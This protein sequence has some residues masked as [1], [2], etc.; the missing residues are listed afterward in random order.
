MV[1]DYFIIGAGVAGLTLRRFLASDSVVVADPKPFKYKIGESM[2]PE[3]FAHPVMRALLPKVHELPSYSRKG[4]STFVDGQNVVKFPLPGWEHGLAI[5]VAR[6]ELEQLMADEWGIDI[7]RE[8][9]L[10]VDL[11]GKR[12]RTD[13]AT[14]EVRRQIIDCSGPAMVLASQLGEVS[15]LWPVWSTWAYYDIEALDPRFDAL[16]GEGRNVLRFDPVR[17]RVL[18]AEELPDW[19]SARTTILTMLRPGV[20]LWQISLAR[21]TLLS[22]G[23][24]SNEGPVKA[25]DLEDAVARYSAPGYKLKARRRDGTDW[26]DRYHSRPGFA[27]RA[28]VAS[29]KDYILLSDAFA[30]ADP[31][32]SVGT[33]L[34][35]NKAI[36]LALLLNAR[37]WDTATS[38]AYNKEYERLIARAVAAFKSWYTGDLV[39]DDT[40][41]ADVQRGYLAGTAFQVNLTR[42]Y[43]HLLR[44]VKLEADGGARREAV[45]DWIAM[46]EIAVARQVGMMLGLGD[47]GTLA[48][49]TLATAVPRGSGLDLHWRRAAGPVLV[50]DVDF[51]EPAKAFRRCGPIALSAQSLIDRPYPHDHQVDELFSSVTD[52]MK[53]K[54]QAWLELRRKSPAGTGPNPS[55]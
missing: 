14:Y 34:A 2:T 16:L 22:A 9:V 31:I 44:D 27:R 33:T 42:H 24:V 38:D 48:G 10:E 32:Y 49:W 52:R 25:V 21:T 29:T 26:R 55:A 28:K 47:D 39:K 19:S 8:R 54:E 40:A 1:V 18:E 4:G 5:H 23:L 46:P 41:A 30:F 36:E 37:E 43:G 45:S 13:R 11:A 6:P 50:M 20:W 3:Q 12:V 51:D 53:N 17:K 15:E 35:T 7:V